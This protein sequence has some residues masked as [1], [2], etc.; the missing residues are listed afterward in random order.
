MICKIVAYKYLSPLP[1][2]PFPLSTGTILPPS[3]QRSVRQY[4]ARVSSIFLVVLRLGFLLRVT[5]IILGVGRHDNLVAN[6][7]LQVVL[8]GSTTLARF[9][10]SPPTNTCPHYFQCH[11][12]FPPVLFCHARLLP[13]LLHESKPGNP[14][15]KQKD[16]M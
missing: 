1:P 5:L 16:R 11:F 4:L 15:K 13:A 8:P 10:K 2:V 6:V 3:V 12:F 9:A 14:W 7:V